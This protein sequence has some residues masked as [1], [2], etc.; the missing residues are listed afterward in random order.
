VRASFDRQLDSLRGRLVV[1]AASVTSAIRWASQCLFDADLAMAGQVLD[2]SDEVA[3]SRRWIEAQAYELLA[4]QQPVATDLRLAWASMQVAGD[5]DRM[6]VLAAHIARTM[7]RRHPGPVVPASLVDVV[8]RMAEIA[9]RL[10]WNVT[11]VLELG[12]MELT[13]EIIRTD[14]EMDALERRLFAIVLTDWSYGVAA[15][16]DAAQL[17]RFYERYAD[18]AV[19]AARHI[20]FL[21][22]GRSYDPDIST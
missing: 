5:L 7:V 20:A 1:M 12:E 19:S 4:L 17:G 14:D 11:R 8:Q 9:E 16:I 6:G 10:A 15:A 13:A 21:I 2:V 22:T 3:G 18:H